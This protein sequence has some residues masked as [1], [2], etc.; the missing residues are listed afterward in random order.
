MPDPLH[1]GPLSD[2]A[3]EYIEVGD[4]LVIGDRE[5]TVT[6]CKTIEEPQMT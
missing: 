2:A 6:S 3:I 5:Y 1:D 4:V